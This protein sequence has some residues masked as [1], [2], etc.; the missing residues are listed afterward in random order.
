MLGARGATSRQL[1]LFDLGV[2]CNRRLVERVSEDEVIVDY[3]NDIDTEMCALLP[4]PAS[5]PHISACQ[6]PK[7]M[8]QPFSLKAQALDFAARVLAAA[9]VIAVDSTSWHPML[10][11]RCLEWP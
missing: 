5:P 11:F 1:I 8:L 10:H 4:R 2:S 7:H 3:A 6:L 9:P